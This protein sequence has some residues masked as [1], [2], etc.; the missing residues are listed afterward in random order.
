MLSFCGRA[1]P[2]SL[3]GICPHLTLSVCICEN[4]S[5]YLEIAVTPLPASFCLFKPHKPLLLI[6][7]L[8]HAFT[9]RQQPTRHTAT[10]SGD[11]VVN[12]TVIVTAP[13]NQSSVLVPIKA[14][15]K[16][17]HGH[18]FPSLAGFHRT[19]IIS[20]LQSTSSKLKS[21]N[22]ILNLPSQ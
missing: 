6:S 3:T 2:S 17:K 18:H 9:S 4:S 20:P 14:E 8:R 22:C 12:K 11:P 5:F 7:K 16:H 1:L 10:K 13:Q 15:K 19:C 21:L